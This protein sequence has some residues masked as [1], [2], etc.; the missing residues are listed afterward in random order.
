MGTD[1]LKDYLGYY[2]FC[3]TAEKINGS[4]QICLGSQIWSP[5]YY[6]NN[7]DFTAIRKLLFQFINPKANQQNQS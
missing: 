6:S 3:Q 2:R 1:L 5:L 7:D 4:W